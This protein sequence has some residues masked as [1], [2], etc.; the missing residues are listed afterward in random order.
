[1][2]LWEGFRHDAGAHRAA[3]LADGELEALLQGDGRDELEVRADVVAG[4]AHARAVGQCDGPRDVRRPAPPR[5]D[6][7]SQGT[8]PSIVAR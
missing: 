1:M 3:T 5:I 4:H 6:V 8:G 7:V 2:N